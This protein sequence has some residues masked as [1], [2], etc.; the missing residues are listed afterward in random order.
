[1]MLRVWE[2]DLAHHPM[3][4]NEFTKDY[5]ES[6]ENALKAEKEGYR[7]SDLILLAIIG[8]TEKQEE[9]IRKEKPFTQTELQAQFDFL[10]ALDKYDK[11][12]RK[13]S[14][15]VLQGTQP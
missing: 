13:T 15:F 2:D 11:K 3:K 4:K 9:K 1:M 10:Q 6:F 12:Y 7:G 14:G 5:K 8:L